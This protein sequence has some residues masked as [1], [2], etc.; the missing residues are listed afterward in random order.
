MYFEC[1]DT[2]YIV[3]LFVVLFHFKTFSNCECLDLNRNLDSWLVAFVCMLRY[4]TLYSKDHGNVAIITPM[5]GGGG[6]GEERGSIRTVLCPSLGQECP[7]QI[8]CCS[9]LSVLSLIH[10][11][12]LQ[13]K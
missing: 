10:P 9:W 5:V 8:H 1:S 4:N 11:P 3:M 13:C 6:S 2:A 12:A 7:Y